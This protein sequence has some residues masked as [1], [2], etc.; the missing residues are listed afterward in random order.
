MATYTVVVGKTATKELEKLPTPVVKKI[1]P[2]IVS[3]E[4]NPSPKGCKKLQGFENLWRIRVGNYRII[5]AIEDVIML[6]DV[7]KI[8]HR[9]DIYE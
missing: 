2:A 4:E 3:L 7:R 5:Y 1:V 8:G 6:V 9:K